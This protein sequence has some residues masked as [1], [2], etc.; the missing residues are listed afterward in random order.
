[1]LDITV[2]LDRKVEVVKSE[3]FAAS[4]RKTRNAQWTRY[5]NFCTTY[6]MDPAPIIAIKVCRF[7]VHLGES[8]KY[9][10]INN[11]VSALNAMGKLSDNFQDLRQDYG[12][13]LVLRGLKRLLGDTRSPMDPRLP[14]ELSRIFQVVDLSDQLELSVWIA[15][16]LA[17]RT[18]LRKSHFF[19]AQD[20]KTHLIHINDVTFQDWG[21]I[22]RVSSSKTIQ[23]SQRHL[24]I[25]VAFCGGPLCAASQL[26]VYLDRFPKSGEAPLISVGEDPVQYPK[27]LA[28]LKQW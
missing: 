12:V 22:I 25:P 17:F 26:K 19:A 24:D 7:L 8:L 2:V 10:T 21:I 4:T 20:D 6:H 11:Y 27:A 3:A 14:F 23:F 1:M 5:V 16:A 13:V 28:L 18:L 15:V 9:S